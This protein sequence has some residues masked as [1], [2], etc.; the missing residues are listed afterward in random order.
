[1][2]NNEQGPV[3][4]PVENPAPAPVEVSNDDKMMAMLATCWEASW[5]LLYR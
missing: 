4:N 3:I 2:E 1:M 5:A